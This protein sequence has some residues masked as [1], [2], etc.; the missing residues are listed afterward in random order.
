MLD[1]IWHHIDTKNSDKV[2]LSKFAGCI[3]DTHVGCCVATNNTRNLPNCLV[4]RVRD[5]LP[6]T[7]R[8][9][10]LL[11]PKGIL[12]MESKNVDIWEPTLRAHT[13]HNPYW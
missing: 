5:G 9:G 8:E 11:T 1:I 13:A 12:S 7:H 2:S 4:L 10:C 3:Y 6:I